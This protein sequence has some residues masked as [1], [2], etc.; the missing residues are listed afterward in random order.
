V[1]HR[2]IEPAKT[3][4]SADGRGWVQNWDARPGGQGV[5]MVLEEGR[6]ASAADPGRL[7]RSSDVV[8]RT[9]WFGD[10]KARMGN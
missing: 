5:V 6:T 4:L 3:G 2:D 10:L 7:R 8:L 9:D 1:I